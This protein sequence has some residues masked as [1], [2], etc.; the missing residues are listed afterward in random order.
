[1][2]LELAILTYLIAVAFLLIRNHLIAEEIVKE[3]ECHKKFNLIEYYE[4]KANDFFSFKTIDGER[5]LFVGDNENHH[6]YYH[7]LGHLIFDDFIADS[8]LD[9][10]ILLPVLLLPIP[11]S[12]MG[13]LF[14][15]IIT[16][17]VKK[18]WERRAD[19]FAFEMTGK[20][21]S[22]IQP[23]S[24]K[25]ILLYRWL[26]WS[27]PPEKVRIENEYYKKEIPLI[28]LFFRSLLA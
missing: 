23:E 7:E 24:N 13:A 5:F 18:N 9:A 28:K 26:F 12:L 19:I 14:L 10:S 6:A 8:F 20:K 17:W 11:W 16:K 25:F 15:Y 22:S 21:Y 27:H 4:C 1:M 2:E 3:L